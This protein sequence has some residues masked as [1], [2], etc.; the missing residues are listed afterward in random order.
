MRLKKII[1]LSGLFLLIAPLPPLSAAD[2][3]SGTCACYGTVTAGAVLPNSTFDGYCPQVKQYCS[4]C[5]GGTATCQ[6]N[7]S[8]TKDDCEKLNTDTGSQLTK[9]GIPSA[10]LLLVNISGSCAFQAAAAEKS[11]SKSTSNSGLIPSC[12]TGTTVPPLSCVLTLLGSISKWILGISGSLALL[13]FVYG[14]FMMLASGGQPGMIGKGKTILTQAVIGLI[15]IFG[16]YFAIDFLTKALGFQESKFEIPKEKSS[17]SSNTTTGCCSYQDTKGANCAD[18]DSS[19]CGAI[20][21][22]KWTSGKKCNTTTK[23][24]Q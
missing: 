13:M 4:S 22:S 20:S 8:S 21:G 16:A 17:S 24:C 2:S 9:F 19:N 18:Y 5:G 3:S 14:G 6:G 11:T 15:I 23:S 10:A 7:F 1:I 12:A